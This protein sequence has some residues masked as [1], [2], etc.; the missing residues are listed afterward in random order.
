MDITLHAGDVVRIRGPEGVVR[1]RVEVEGGGGVLLV[2]EGPGTPPGR[3][4]TCRTCGLAFDA[5]G[6]VTCP[7]CGG[8]VA[9]V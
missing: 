1:M 6:S 7:R 2:M 9:D 3:A 5:D 8:V 4:V